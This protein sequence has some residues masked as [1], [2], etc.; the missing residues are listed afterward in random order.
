MDR[1]RQEEAAWRATVDKI[2]QRRELAAG[3]LPYDGEVIG[4]V[5]RSS[6]QS[7]STDIAV[8]AADASRRASQAVA[9]FDAGWLSH[10]VWLLH[11]GL[12]DRGGSGRWPDRIA[13]SSS[14]WAT[15][16]I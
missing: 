4:A 15:A 12:R 7:T 5:Q 9:H 2:T 1:A 3:E 14:W 6:P 16:A 11:H 13:K 8:C 10:G